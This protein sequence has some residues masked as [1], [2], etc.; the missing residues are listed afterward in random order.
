M[1]WPLCHDCKAQARYQCCRDK[2]YLCSSHH[3]EFHLRHKYVCIAGEVQRRQV[4]AQM[5]SRDLHSLE[6]GLQVGEGLV[7]KSLSQAETSVQEWTETLEEWLAVHRLQLEALQ[8]LAANGQSS[9]LYEELLARLR[10]NFSDPL[11]RLS[12]HLPS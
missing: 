4:L 5:L 6:Q 1:D 7:F 8:T 11:L 2:Q 12:V 3:R 9:E 10:C